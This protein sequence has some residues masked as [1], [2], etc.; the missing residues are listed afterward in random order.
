MY[1]T[2]HNKRSF[3]HLSPYLI[4]NKLIPFGTRIIMVQLKYRKSP[5]DS[6]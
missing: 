2:E 1:S 6:K 3:V 4:Y 5:D